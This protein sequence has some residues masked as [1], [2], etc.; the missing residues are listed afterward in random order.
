MLKVWRWDV[1]VG[2]I[3]CD[4][5]RCMAWGRDEFFLELDMT[6]VAL[7]SGL[8]REGMRYD[9]YEIRESTRHF[10]DGYCII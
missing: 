9:A 10:C 8:G 4:M 5:A 3:R 2:M 6:R 7:R 1:G